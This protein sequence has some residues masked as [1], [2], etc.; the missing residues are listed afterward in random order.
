MVAGYPFKQFYSLGNTP[1]TYR[2]GFAIALIVNG[3]Q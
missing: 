2:H 1:E 3:Q